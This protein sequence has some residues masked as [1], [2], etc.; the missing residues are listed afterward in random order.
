VE[1]GGGGVGGNRI[2][3]SIQ[4]SNEGPLPSCVSMQQKTNTSSE[5]AGKQGV[6]G[7]QTAWE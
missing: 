6:T 4:G 7:G 1:K 2:R 5:K 3:V